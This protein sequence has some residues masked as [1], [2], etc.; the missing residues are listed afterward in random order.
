MTVEDWCD[1]SK[2]FDI[3]LLADIGA[4]PDQAHQE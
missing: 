3:K 2:W 1:N 4:Q